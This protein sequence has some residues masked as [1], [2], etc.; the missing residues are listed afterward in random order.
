MFA[1]TLFAGSFLLFLVEPMTAK[2]ILPTF[3]GAPMVWNT[4]VMFF[5]VV[6][7]LGYA[8]AHGTASSV[9]PKVQ[10]V[11]Y[12]L[13]LSLPFFALPIG[14]PA[15]LASSTPTHPVL[16][17]IVLLSAM[18]ALPFFV[19]STSASVLQRAFAHTDHPAAPDPYF[20]YAASNLGSLVALLSYPVLVEPLIALHDQVRLWSIGYQCFAALALVCVLV[21]AGRSRSAPATMGELGTPDEPDVSPGATRQASRTSWRTR[22]GW[23][24]WSF[25]PSSLML[26]VTTYLSTDVAAVTLLWIVPL[27]IYLLTFVLAFSFRRRGLQI[28]AARRLPLLILPL[29]SLM[30]IRLDL[31][32]GLAIPFHLAVFA[33]AALL[34]HARLAA[35]RPPPAALTAFYFWI[36]LG[37]L[38]GGVFS[39]LIAPRIFS[40]ISEYPILL[41]L[42]CL[43]RADRKELRLAWGDLI[44][45]AGI[46]LVAAAALLGVRALALPGLASFAALA[47]PMLAAFSQSRRGVRF[48][49]SVGAIFVAGVAVVS[50]YGRVSYTER[51]FFGVYRV[52]LDASSRYRVLFHGTT[53]HGWEALDPA[54][55]GEPLAYYHRNGPF[56]QAF[57]QLTQI[58]PDDQVAVVGLGIGSLAAYATGH[59]RWTFFEIDPAIERIARRADFFSF[60]ASC[61][62]RCRVII[63]DARLSLTAAPARAYR[64]IVLDAFSSDAIPIHLLTREALALYLSRLAS[65]GVLAFHVSNRHLA[66]GPVLGRLASD[67]KL[68]ALSQL[69]VVT[70]AQQAAG[71]SSSEWLFMARTPGD[72]GSLLDNPQWT[73]PAVPSEMPLWTDDF[74][75]IL[76]AL[77]FSAR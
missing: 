32:N 24:A 57:S 42:A 21:S 35:S 50:P 34:C 9:R 59:Q 43:A 58:L 66:L 75:N 26:A 38:L 2:M 23:V 65:H 39:T 33:L 77:H 11:G 18:V 17:V 69:Q 51:T 63:G 60:L 72:L 70:A 67:A 1:A 68:S 56:G 37:G 44:V 16:G 41:V 73:A 52:S 61:G 74:S 31:A 49:L 45:P 55:A 4:C 5:Q 6:L 10:T 25:V 7:L 64:L 13:L 3:G 20:L 48:A 27:S 12:A 8:Y 22:A 29:I 30:A 76:S 71:M 47:V 62:E 46:G 14:V 15:R 40:G 28:M 36:A 19:L 53:Q 54:R